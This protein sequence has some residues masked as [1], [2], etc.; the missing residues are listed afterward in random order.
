MI[1]KNEEKNCG[2]DES[3]KFFQEVRIQFLIHELKDPVS[4][5]ESGVKMLLDRRDKFGELS[6]KQERT[7]KR[8][9]RN[10]KKAR[11]M[12]Y[13][14]LEIGRSE[15]G[16][17]ITGLFDPGRVAYEV[18]M[19]A[20]EIV[21]WTVYEGCGDCRNE[22]E[23]VLYL[24]G[25]GVFLEIDP[26]LSNFEINQDETKYRHILGNLIKNALHY[27]KKRLD[28]RLERK[29]GSISVEVRDDGPGIDPKYH[30]LVFQRYTR[31]RETYASMDRSG[32]GLG[33]AGALILARSLG[34][35]IEL[36]SEKGK[37]ALFRLTLPITKA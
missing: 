12:L 29:N 26:D 25:K 8:T 5:V 23:T 36:E 19:E 2:T 14:L 34:G 13:G 1:G 24:G 27:R 16:S 7:L 11:E 10:A 3:G 37:G 33:L 35:D 4:I 31:A 22:T 9:L 32:H 15:E 21:D 17:H 30:R 18:L 20:L 28:I 6:P